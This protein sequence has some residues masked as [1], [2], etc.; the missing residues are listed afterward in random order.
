MLYLARHG[1]TEA[2]CSPK[3]LGPKSYKESNL[4]KV[5][6]DQANFYFLN[7][8]WS[9]IEFV[10]C[11]TAL[12]AIETAELAVGANVSLA[13]IITTGLLDEQNI[14][15]YDGSSIDEV[16]ANLVDCSAEYLSTGESGESALN[17]AHRLDLFYKKY[18]VELAKDC[19][20]ITHNRAMRVITH[21]NCL[22]AVRWPILLNFKHC[23]PIAY[24]GL[25]SLTKQV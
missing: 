22:E 11:S 12:G 1:E 21:R 24:N 8:N 17:V 3:W 20:I 15:K 9:T 16:S 5:G 25:N 6:R 18:S 13:D 23:K 10:F 4:T 19:I 14:G 2:D 7:L